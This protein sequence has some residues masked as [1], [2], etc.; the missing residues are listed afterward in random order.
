MLDDGAMKTSE[1]AWVAGG[2]RRRPSL[3]GTC[4]SDTIEVTATWVLES[5]TKVTGP[6]SV[7]VRGLTWPGHVQRGLTTGSLR[8]SE[9]LLV[10]IVR[11]LPSQLKQTEFVDPFIELR[12]R[13][14]LMPRSPREDADYYM[15]LEALYQDV[16][17]AG[18]EKPVRD[19][20]SLLGLPKETV[21]TQIAAARRRRSQPKRA[22]KREGCSNV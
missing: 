16:M 12:E 2:S 22:S 20:A 5:H 17:A 8:A 14:R 6:N 1:I 15:K 21:R 18:S 9:S 3:S 7:T 13:V 10:K 4:S 11:E 19:V